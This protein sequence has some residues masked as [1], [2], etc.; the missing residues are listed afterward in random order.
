MADI[1]EI[2]KLAVD[3]HN[4][5][6]KKYSVEQSQDLLRQAL[7][8][9]NG[10]STTLDYRRIR[11]GKCLGLFALIEEI[12]GKTTIDG[13]QDDP[14][15]KA[16]VEFRNIAEGDKNIFVVKDS[17]LFVVADAAEGTQGIR[18][19]RLGAAVETSIPTVLKVVKIYEEL[20]RILANRVDFN[21]MIDQ[22]SKSFRQ[23]L[24]DD[25][26]A[27]WDGVVA[28]QLGGTTYFPAAGAYDEDTLLDLVAHVEAAANGKPA[29]IIGTMKAV[30]HLAPS[31]TTVSATEDLYNN[32]YYGKFFGTPVVAVPQRHKA[33]T[34]IFAMRDD[35]LTVIAGD[36]K[37]IKI[38]NEGEPLVIM[39][40]P[41]ANNDLTQE[42]F[43]GE[44][45]GMGIITAGGNAGI[46]RYEITG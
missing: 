3:G 16:L 24:L 28:E 19:Q 14:L 44:K 36:E 37:P 39:G 46:G 45:I 21:Y 22:V 30:R 11:D 33:G 12:L 27:L 1:K 5:T 6:V 10:G 2:V 20:K 9:A 26:Y 38:V 42:F 25:V 7:I 43:Y 31:I 23:K 4:G 8:E 32:G 34:D 13:I 35:V 18:R 41:L 40:D 29:A 17:N 15:F